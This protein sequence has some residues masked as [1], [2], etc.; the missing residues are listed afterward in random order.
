MKKLLLGCLL[1]VC[2][3]TGLYADPAEDAQ[4][5][6]FYNKLKQEAASLDGASMLADKNHRIIYMALP[7][8]ADKAAVIEKLDALKE[9]MITGIRKD[10]NEY[11]TI[12]SLKIRIVVSY[13]TTDEDIVS[14]AISFKDL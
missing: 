12:K 11:T 6:K 2:V 8:P 14:T 3:C 5:Q 13:I 7:V 1:A 9:S 4:F 10:K